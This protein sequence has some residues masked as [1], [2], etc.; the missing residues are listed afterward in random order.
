MKK[1]LQAALLIGLALFCAGCG[2][3]SLTEE[4]NDLIAQYAAHQV[5]QNNPNYDD[6][7]VT[8]ETPD[9]SAD[10]ATTTQQSTTTQETSQ[11][12]SAD[13]A[14][15]ATTQET[16]VD[17]SK[18]YKKEKIQVKYRGYKVVKRYQ[19]S[20][21]SSLD[22]EPEEGGSLLAVKFRVSNQTDKT[23]TTDLLDA[24]YQYTLHTDSKTVEPM[25]TILE[26]D[27][28]SLQVKLKPGQKKTAVLLFE[29]PK[30]A[31]KPLNYQLDITKGSD[32]TTIEL[33]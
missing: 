5:L 25:L 22:V 7:L 21:Q 12:T 13:T 26:S 19:D 31:K 17:L 11:G 4:Q 29:I 20:N 30:G 27:L 14:A 3:D 24:G 18:V 28:S 10:A 2:K 32:T 16:V 23:V 9:A 33:Q 6:R 1:T 8:T 15:E